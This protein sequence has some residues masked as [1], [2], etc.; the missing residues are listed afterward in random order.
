MNTKHLIT[1]VVL[2]IVAL[3]VA[4]LL[5]YYCVEP[6]AAGFNLAMSDENISEVEVILRENLPTSFTMEVSSGLPRRYTVIPS[7]EF[8]SLKE[9]LWDNER[10]EITSAKQENGD[11]YAFFNNPFDERDYDIT[12]LQEILNNYSLEA[13]EINRI[14]VR[15]GDYVRVSEIEG[16]LHLLENE[17]NMIKVWPDVLKR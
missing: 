5:F 6:S 3:Y 16:T 12:E 14:Y 4:G 10:M 11:T 7:S 1:I 2:A 17:S 15:F 13:R 9:T 8:N